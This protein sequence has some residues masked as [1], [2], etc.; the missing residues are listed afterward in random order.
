M[1]DRFYDDGSY[2]GGLI[3]KAGESEQAVFFDQYTRW[4]EKNGIVSFYF[5]SFDENWKGGFD[6]NNAMDKAEKHWGL[7]N[8][9][10]TPKVVLQ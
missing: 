6:G 9:D 2:E 8:S 4:I 3:G 1:R 7:Y 10:R 5:T